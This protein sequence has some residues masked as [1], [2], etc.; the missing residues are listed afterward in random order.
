[1]DNIDGAIVYVGKNGE[2][3]ALDNYVLV[4]QAP[5]DTYELYVN[6]DIDEMLSAITLIWEAIKEEATSL[7][8]QDL[9]ELTG[10]YNLDYDT[11]RKQVRDA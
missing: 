1:M 6:A 7:S 3:E 5:A 9:Y 11:F 2:L 10:E 8:D 4:R